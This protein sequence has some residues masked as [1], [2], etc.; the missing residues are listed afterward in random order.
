M[1]ALDNVTV[2]FVIRESWWKQNGTTFGRLAER[3]RCQLI[4]SGA[5][6][7]VG[8]NRYIY[9]PLDTPANEKAPS[10]H[11]CNTIFLL[12]FHGTGDTGQIIRHV[13]LVYI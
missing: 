3:H 12:L 5:F 11:Y 10:L 8:N 4:F 7:C 2:S 6:L 9:K 1:N 13:V